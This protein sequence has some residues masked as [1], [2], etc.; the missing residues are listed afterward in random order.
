MTI[1]E[2]AQ[3][4]GVSVSTVSKVMNGKD[5]G[6]SAETRQRVLAVAKEYHY[7]PYATAL[8]QQGRTL[9]LGVLVKEAQVTQAAIAGIVSAASENGY[10]I[11]LREAAGSE[12]EELKALSS[13]IAQ[14]VD[15]ILWEPASDE[16]LVLTG[17]I[18]AAGIPYL[19]FGCHASNALCPDYAS[20]GY[21][22]TDELA[23]RGHAS[24]A[25]VT[26]ESEEAQRFR[27]G[28]RQCLFDHHLP[29]NEALECSGTDVDVE[30]SI[31]RQS[32]A[33][34]LSSLSLA[35]RFQQEVL[36]LQRHIPS[37]YSIVALR[38][39][40]HADF[41]WLPVSTIT[42]GETEFGRHLAKRLL[43]VVEKRGELA[44]SDETHALDSLVSVDV[45]PRLR[46]KGIVS[47]G[48]INVDTYLDFENLPHT[49]T[50]ASTS[51]SAVYPGGKC[52]NE[53]I[54]AAKLGHAAA[55]IGKV[56]DDTD[57]DMVLDAL[58]AH[59][60]DVSAIERVGGQRTGQAY[61]FV[62]KT[63]ASMISIV[64]GANT[65][66][67]P[68]DAV[69]CERLFENAAI[70]LLQTEVSLEA[71]SQAASIAKGHG[72]ITILKPSDCKAL[73]ADLLSNIDILAPNL[74]ELN[75]ICPG[76]EPMERKVAALQNRGAG[77]VIVT[78]GA[79]GCCVFERDRQTRIASHKVD[80]IDTTGAGDAF[81]S[82]LA[83]Y[84]LYGRDVV[85][86]S[87]IATYAA[88]LS[89]L[90]QGVPQALVDRETLEAYIRQHDP[91]LLG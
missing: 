6:I 37:D 10:S 75:A 43:D 38:K 69:A 59:D 50:S 77:T 58:I 71:I 36:G 65:A 80:S 73:P 32:S 2:I 8:Q 1:K 28:Y 85:S 26:D 31:I 45:A 70:C 64:S 29:W 13:L 51:M 9:T 78:M 81:I 57:A 22:S 86:A 7:K 40:A 27:E 21:A 55:A 34:V 20:L 90:R 47:F 24:I 30:R 42:V 83:A 84:L 39:E 82:A 62:D 53:A 11:L 4:A 41:P 60:V 19:T 44:H 88:A 14:H 79:E 74:D 17:R 23:K 12:E 16:S 54:G 91:E 66:L 89:T 46:Q 48:S 5:D 15:G 33:A 35:L 56:G 72:A 18:D 67:A 61:I 63:G 87:R 49:G 68:N 25:C 3:L 52:L 76:E